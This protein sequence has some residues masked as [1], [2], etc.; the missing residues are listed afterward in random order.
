MFSENKQ[1]RNESGKK[2]SE[3]NGTVQKD[4]NRRQSERSTHV[5]AHTGA[6]LRNGNVRGKHINAQ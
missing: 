1:G 4:R 3:Q 2:N 6:G 5:H